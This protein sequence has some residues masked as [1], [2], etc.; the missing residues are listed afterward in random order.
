MG[1]SE[2]RASRALGW[3]RTVLSTILRRLDTGSNITSSSGG[4]RSGF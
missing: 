1:W 3:D 4:P 2:S